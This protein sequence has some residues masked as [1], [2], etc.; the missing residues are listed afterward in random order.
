[1]TPGGLVREW[2]SETRK[3]GQ[4][5]KHVNWISTGLTL[6]RQPSKKPCRVRKLGYLSSYSHASFMEVGPYRH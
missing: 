3:E 2:A 6:F 1:M 4:P 5:I